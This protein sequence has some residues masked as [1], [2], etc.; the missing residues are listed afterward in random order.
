MP[1]FE[2]LIPDEEGTS[3]TLTVQANNWLGAL[4]TGLRNLGETQAI[5]NVM[6]DIKED[7]SIHVTEPS[8]GRVFRL[9]EVP[10]PAGAAAQPAAP[11]P[12]PP[13]PPPPPPAQAAPVAAKPEPAPAKPAPAVRP[14]APAPA[15]VKP[16]AAPVARA[17]APRPSVAPTPAQV[18]KD[19]V[20][21]RK[22]TG[23]F[24]DAGQVVER[25]H[26]RDV[27]LAAVGRKPQA[28]PAGFKVEDVL[29]DMFE[30]MQD[31]YTGKL[32]KERIA[33]FL[34]DLALQHVKSDAGTFYTSG[35]SGAD[36]EFTAVRGPKADQLKR[37]GFKVPVGQGIVGFCAQEGVSL[38]ISDVMNDER[39]M[40]TVSDKIGYECHNMVCAPLYRGGRLWGAIQLINRK[41]GDSYASA[42]VD[43]LNYIAHE[44]ASLLATVEGE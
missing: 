3:V 5:S 13:A 22:G 24:K 8:S 42:E 14:A 29:A 15:A 18:A 43:V 4:K 35:L 28:Q 1:H 16:A 19:V 34:L 27:N 31:L 20:A 37:S 30:K 11:P 12:A 41:G 21:A 39:F 40:R 38:A 33:G 32:D 36:L 25:K 6:C 26:T 17:A 7:S 23:Q 9:R 10:A 2:V 44:G